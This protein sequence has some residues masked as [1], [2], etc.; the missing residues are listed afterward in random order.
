[1]PPNFAAK[2]GITPKFQSPLLIIYFLVFR[3][4]N[5]LGEA[6]S[7]LTV[8]PSRFRSLNKKPPLNG[9]SAHSQANDAVL[10]AD[11]YWRPACPWDP[12]SLQTKPAGSPSKI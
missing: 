7:D 9:G 5:V 1:M 4:E 11:E 3:Q 8:D 10:K 6:L 2:I 12:S